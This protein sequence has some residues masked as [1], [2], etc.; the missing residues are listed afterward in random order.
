MDL[1]LLLVL[2]SVATYRITRLVT[3][4]TLP[5]ALWIRDRLAGGWR[6]AEDHE[7]PTDVI[8]GVPSVYNK[9]APW[10]TH[11]V[12]KLITCNWC[13]S[14]YVAAGVVGTV[15]V[16]DGLPLPGLLWVSVW[17]AGALLAAQDWA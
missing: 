12:G 1:W 13:A 10:S 9:R 2:M 7:T 14:A 8:D 16:V 5:P 15:W 11:W 17:G 4:D 3:T 6:E